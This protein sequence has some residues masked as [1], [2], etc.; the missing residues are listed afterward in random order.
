VVA[1]GPNEDGEVSGEERERQRRSPHD[2][3][4]SGDEREGEGASGAEG[5]EMGE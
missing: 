1:C 2:R 3:S 4:S 5:F